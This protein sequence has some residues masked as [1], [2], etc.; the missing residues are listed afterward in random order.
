MGRVKCAMFAVCVS[1]ASSHATPYKYL[2]NLSLY[3][4]VALK[5]TLDNPTQV[6]I[7]PLEVLYR[8]PT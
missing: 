3:G 7:V 5:W 1:L 4:A 8:Q 6:R 2:I